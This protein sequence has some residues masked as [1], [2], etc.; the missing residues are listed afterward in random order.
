MMK[1]GLVGLPNVGKSSFFNLLTEANV[2]VDLYPFTTI[3]KNVGIVVVPD[4][5]LKIIGDILK[6]PKLTYATI[7]FIDIAGLV[8]GASQG[9]GLGN[10]FLSHI[11]ETDLILHII[12]NFEDGSIPH[13]YN[14]I[15]PIRDLEIVESELA[16]ADL[17]I[18]KRNTEKLRKSAVSVEEK[19]HLKILDDLEDSLSK[20]F[21]S[22]KL[23]SADRQLIK[24]LNLF[25]LKPC[26]YAINCSDKTKTDSEALLNLKDKNTFLFSIAL[27]DGLD[28]FDEDEK[29][30]LRQS[31]G[32]A[33]N[34]ISGIVEECFKRLDLIRFY[35]IKGD[36]SRAWA[37]PRHTNIVDAAGKIHT[38]MA[39]GFIKAEVVQFNDLVACGDFHNA[40]EAG[41][42]RI[43]G[44]NYLV[45]D[46]DIILVKFA[47]H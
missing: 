32:L 25:V 29:L 39:S 16:L 13:I 47:G 20:G 22:S 8:K 26:I 43:E 34:G 44:K 42:I 28:G 45:K 40:R 30:E 41:H 14:T 15:E 11:R 35:T 46:G 31:L 10:K 37:V 18:I 6:P 36:E 27:E 24:D 7:E 1:V 21:F 23:E 33:I 5:R 19:H 17:D 38:D 4:E 12:R 9:E 3:E 2:K